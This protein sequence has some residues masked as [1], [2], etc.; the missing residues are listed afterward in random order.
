MRPRCRR[1]ERFALSHSRK[2]LD[3][4]GQVFGKLRVIGPAASRNGRTRWRCLC[5]GCGRET[6]VSTAHLTTGHTRSC[7][8]SYETS[9]AGKPP[10]GLT[11]VEGTCVEMIRAGTVRRN[12]KSG[13]PGVDWLPQRHRWRASICFQGKRRFLGSYESYEDAVAARKRAEEE[14]HTPFLKRYEKRE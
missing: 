8:C 10:P 11:L 5:E 3:L 7:G 12:N 1:K 9:E 14:L 2:K 6:E 4:T 13:V